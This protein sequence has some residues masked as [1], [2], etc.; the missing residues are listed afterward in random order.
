MIKPIKILYI[1][2][3]TKSTFVDKDLRL[4][5]EKFR[6]SEYK[7]NTQNKKLLP[8]YFFQ[9]AFFLVRN[10]FKHD[11]YII[12]FGGY[13]SFLPVVLAK[14][15]NKKSIIINGGTDC[16]SFPSI[17]YGS[18]QKSPIAWFTKKSFLN[19]SHIVTLHSSLMFQNYKYMDL[20]YKSQGL[21]FHIPNLKTPSTTIYNGYD[22]NFWK[23]TQKKVPKSFITVSIG[24]GEARRRAVKGIDLVLEIAPRFPDCQFIIVGTDPSELHDAPKNVILLTKKTPIELVP[25]YS[26]A[27][28]YLQLSM[29]EGFPNSLCEAMLCECVPIVSDV[30]SMPFIVS[31]TGF[32]LKKKDIGLLKSLISDALSS[33][34]NALGQKA[35]KRISEN[36]TETLRQEKLLNLVANILKD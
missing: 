2:P 5:A 23:A 31:D 18:L 21:Q 1:Y 29:S 36:F 35:R 9:Q 25:I 34:T 4:L 6:V 24:L 7:F 26:E 8:L 12:M 19:A 30:A 16:V 11:L 22:A 17:G 33:D 32:V 14:F 10:I 13:W 20:E 3:G 27:T 15:F 28:F